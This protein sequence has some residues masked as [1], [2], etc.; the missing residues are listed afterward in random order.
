MYSKYT[1]FIDINDF[2]PEEWEELIEETIIVKKFLR[3]YRSNDFNAKVMASLFFEDSTRT[4]LSFQSAITTPGGNFFELGSNS[5]L[6][7]G[8]TLKDTIIMTSGYSDIM[9]IRHKYAGAAKVAAMYA[10]CP[11]INAGDGEHFHPTQTLT[12]LFTMKEKKGRLSSLK[13]GVC[14]DLKLG[15]TSHS[16]CRALSL[17]PN[18]HFVLIACK[19]FEMPQDICDFIT[20][21]NCTYEIAENFTDSIYDLDVLYMT[22]IQKERM[23]TVA[24]VRNYILD[25]KMLEKA[26]KDLIIMHPLPRNEE[27]AEE[28]D[29]DNRAVYFEQANNGVYCRIVLMKKLMESD[30]QTKLFNGEIKS[31]E[32]QNYNCITKYE[33]YLPNYFINTDKG[34]KCEYCD[35]ILG[36]K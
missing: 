8:E 18:N 31:E 1:H 34:W 19:G 21:N 2:S 16:L 17:Y 33:K 22:R 27:I 29:G 9:A 35:F 12:D 23:K 25:C 26:K 20:A 6:N 13:I 24:D 15:R 10:T 7:K 11:V 32:C 14:G 4:R 28:V 3:H 30:R 5:S 36:E